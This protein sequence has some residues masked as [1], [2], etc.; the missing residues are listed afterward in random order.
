M[1]TI[2]T[3]KSMR[4]EKIYFNTCNVF[5]LAILLL[6]LL[7]PLSCSP[8]NWPEDDSNVNNL[9]I[10]YNEIDFFHDTVMG[11]ISHPLSISQ[12]ILFADSLRDSVINAGKKVWITGYIVGTVSKSI[13]TGVSFTVPT[14]IA[15]NILLADS[16]NESNIS[17]CVPIELLSGSK[18][19]KA[20]N[21]KDN[22][23]LL[24]EKIKIRGQITKYYTVTGLKKTD[25]FFIE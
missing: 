17:Y 10:N 24:G 23:K 6:L 4:R 20:L 9:G 11:S 14:D 3:T 15:S 2:F 22:S 16:I 8:P 1:Q 18:I 25:S 21:L 12:T 19:R 13:K 7:S 5:S